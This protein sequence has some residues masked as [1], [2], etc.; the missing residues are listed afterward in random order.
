MTSILYNPYNSK[1]R[2]FTKTDIHAILIKHNCQ[3]S[4]RNIEVFQTAM[5]HSSYV[6]RTEYTTPTG[7]VTTLAP[8][9][10]NSLDLFVE[11]YEILEH[12]GDSIL[13]AV[14]STYLIK[15][16]PQEN[17][18]FLTDLKQYIVCNDMLGSLS[19]KL[20]LDKFYI[21]SRHN[22][23]V[24]NGR[25]NIKKLG[26]ILEAFIGALWTDSG[27]NF[28]VVSK[29]VVSLIE[30]YINIPKLLLNNKN[31]KE[32][33]QKIFQSKFHYTPKYLMLSSAGNMYTMAVT[34]ENGV[35]LGVGAATTK[36][37]AEQFAAKQAME[38]IG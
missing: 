31:Y 19:Q 17:E 35:H 6:K 21:I 26:D 14:V 8:R 24:C 7:E 32:Q 1:N 2:L 37:Q 15:R 20:G 36:K 10:D 22:E 4:V 13:G 12:L 29:F 23:D 5:V 27:N 25:A 30:T 16:F 18:G 28:Q 38:K 11:S 34:D 3:F 33:L 9:Q